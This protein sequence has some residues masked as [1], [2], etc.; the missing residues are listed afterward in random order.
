MTQIP[1]DTIKTNIKSILDAAN[2]TTGSPVDLSNGLNTRVNSVFKFHPGRIS[3]QASEYPYIAMFVPN[4]QI[5][6][7]TIGNRGTQA[8]SLRRGEVTIN[9]VGC[10]YEPYFTD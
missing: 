1:L 10:C 9:I 3:V 6:Q 4:I 5:Q 2:T 8:S 7:L